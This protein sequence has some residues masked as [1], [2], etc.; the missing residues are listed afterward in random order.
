MAIPSPIVLESAAQEVTDATSHPV[1]PPLRD[2]A[3]QR[4]VPLRL[5]E[6]RERGLGDMLALLGVI[7]VAGPLVIAVAGMVVVVAGTIVLLA[8]ALTGP[9][10]LPAILL[11]ALV[12]VA[13]VATGAA[14]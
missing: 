3:D 9:F 2:R 8:L 6:R 1:G 7:A 10:L 13:L 14:G 12:V 11:A 4:P 5:G